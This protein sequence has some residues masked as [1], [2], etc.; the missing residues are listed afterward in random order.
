MK[1]RLF[2]KQ[3]C[4][5]S[6]K[7]DDIIVYFTY[8]YHFFVEYNNITLS[9]SFESFINLP[10]SNMTMITS[11]QKCHLIGEES[12]EWLS[13]TKKSLKNYECTLQELL[14]NNNFYIMAYFPKQLAN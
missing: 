5:R 2:R 10:I 12:Q 1:R 13:K 6:G 8:I 9:Y 11:N 7:I 14:L 4:I 3:K